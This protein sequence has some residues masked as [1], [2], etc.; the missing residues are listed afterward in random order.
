MR[1]VACFHHERFTLQTGWGAT[2][3]KSQSDDLLKVSL[4]VVD[5]QTCE[6]YYEEA[7]F[8]KKFNDGQMCA[9]GKRGKDVIN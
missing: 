2:E 4:D 1:N 7:T 8:T 9:G 6:E 3:T 5:T